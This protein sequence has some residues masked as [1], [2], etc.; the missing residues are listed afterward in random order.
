ME[1]SL[2]GKGDL[3]SNSQSKTKVTRRD[4]L[5]T[6]AALAVAVASPMPALA[7]ENHAK[8]AAGVDYYDK[9][10]VQTF[11]NAAGTYTDLSSACMPEPVQEAVALAAKKWVRIRE[12]QQKAGA[13]VANR[14][15]TEGCCITAGAA[16]AITMAAAA[17]I[18][19]A[20]N[21]HRHAQIPEERDHHADPVW[22]RRGNGPMRREDRGRE[23]A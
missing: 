1:R 22:I 6:Q 7:A 16:S 8:P 10:G 14:L 13:Y 19:A 17:C 20:N 2:L 23:Y 4:F 3:M 18:Q 9:L 12:L 5:R 11:I 15:K 21:C